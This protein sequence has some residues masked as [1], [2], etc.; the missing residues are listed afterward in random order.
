MRFLE[1]TTVYVELIACGH[2]P[3]DWVFRVD[4]QFELWHFTTVSS[5][6]LCCMYGIYLFYY[7]CAVNCGYWVGDTQQAVTN[8]RQ[9]IAIQLTG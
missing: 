5:R 9:G 7:P 8:N 1:C 3:H 2:R 4:R 6:Q